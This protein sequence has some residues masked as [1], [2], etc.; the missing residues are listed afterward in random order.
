[1][2]SAF[3]VER[4]E[5]AKMKIKGNEVLWISENKNI[6]LTYAQFDLG[7]KYKVLRKIKYGLEYG[8]CDCNESWEFNNA[9]I[10]QGEALNYAKKMNDC[11][12]YR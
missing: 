11:D 5:V 9:F 4:M 2:L 3:L 6:V 7:S 1:M 12:I 10:T 8:D